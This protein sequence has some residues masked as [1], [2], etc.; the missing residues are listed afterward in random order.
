MKNRRYFTYFNATDPFDPFGHAP[1]AGSSPSCASSA[2][3]M[4]YL[5]EDELVEICPNSIRIRKRLLKETDRRRQAR[6]KHQ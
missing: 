3:A 6:K 2:T 1:V 5:Q 4:E